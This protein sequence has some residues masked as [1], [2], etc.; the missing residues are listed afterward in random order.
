VFYFEH[1]TKSSLPSA[2]KKTL[3]K[4]NTLSKDECLPSVFSFAL[5]KE[6]FAECIIFALG[7]DE[8]LPSVFLDSVKN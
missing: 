7:K 6:L 4:I 1:S 2:I 8:S 5:S 3:G